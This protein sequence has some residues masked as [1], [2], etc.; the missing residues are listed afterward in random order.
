M[1]P[2]KQVPLRATGTIRIKMQV[3]QGVGAVNVG[4]WFS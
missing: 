3:L 1:V 4:T 2:L